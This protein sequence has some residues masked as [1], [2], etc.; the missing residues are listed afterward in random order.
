MRVAKVSQS[1]KAFW[2]GVW[3][4]VLP[5]A[6]FVAIESYHNE[7]VRRILALGGKAGAWAT[8]MVLQDEAGASSISDQVYSMLGVGVRYRPG[9]RS[10]AGAAGN[11]IMARRHSYCAEVMQ[12]KYDDTPEEEIKAYFGRCGVR[13][14]DELLEALEAA[15]GVSLGRPE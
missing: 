2:D 3:G 15:S 9:Q 8:A 4:A 5:E 1:R 13:A 12:A 11:A 14:S 6:A 10:V 7:T